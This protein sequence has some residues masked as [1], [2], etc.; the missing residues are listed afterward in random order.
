MRTIRA[1]CTVPCTWR[2]RSAAADRDTGFR[3]LH[4]ACCTTGYPS[5]AVSASQSRTCGRRP[6]GSAQECRYVKSNGG[7]SVS[8]SDLSHLRPDRDWTRA[9]RDGPGDPDLPQP[10][11]PPSPDAPRPGA[12]E[13]Q[14]LAEDLL[15]AL[16]SGTS[17]T[18]NWLVS[19]LL[20]QLDNS[21]QCDLGRARQSPV[22]LHSCTR[23]RAVPSALRRFFVCQPELP[24]REE[25][26]RK[27][28]V[29]LSGSGRR[30]LRRSIVRCHLG[31]DLKVRWELCA[32]PTGCRL[33]RKRDS[34]LA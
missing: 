26:R 3:S 32:S 12:S 16:P 22:V 14:R 5:I 33:Y 6:S 23:A 11:R 18:R 24:D 7:G 31:P 27:G 19:S 2:S 13:H 15:A 4:D 17:Q 30:H 20:R 1:V 21:W 25:P 9:H 28:H 34:E 8:Q 29:A 10:A